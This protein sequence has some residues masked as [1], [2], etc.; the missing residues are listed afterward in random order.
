MTKAPIMMNQE[1]ILLWTPKQS[2]Q[3]DDEKLKADEEE[4]EGIG[5]RKLLKS[6]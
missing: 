4:I 6:F 1:V 3:D 2:H 5:W